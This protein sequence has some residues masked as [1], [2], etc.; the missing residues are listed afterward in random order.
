M[1]DQLT[2]TRRLCTPLAT[3][4][5]SCGP[6][7]TNGS[8]HTGASTTIPTNPWGTRFGVARGRAEPAV[9]I[10]RGRAHSSTAAAAP[11]R[12]DG[13]GTRASLRTPLRTQQIADRCVRQLRGAGPG[14]PGGPPKTGLDEPLPCLRLAGRC[15]Q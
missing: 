14:Q 15:D 13:R 10:A 11:A 12:R 3:I 9:A 2:T 4:L 7:L 5:S 8:G 1:V 6:R